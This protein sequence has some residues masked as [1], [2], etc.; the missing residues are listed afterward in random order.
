MNLWIGGSNSPIIVSHP[1]VALD[2]GLLICS[3]VSTVRP[4]VELDLSVA[5]VA[6]ILRVIAATDVTALRG[7]LMRVADLLDAAWPL[8]VDAVRRE[9]R[10]QHEG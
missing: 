8:A 2:R 5:E 4:K 3:S 9:I 6:S 1:Q 7:D 10:I